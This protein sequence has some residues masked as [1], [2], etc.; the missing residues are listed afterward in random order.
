MTG[1]VN[2]DLKGC[3]KIHKR[4]EKL[5]KINGKRGGNGPPEKKGFYEVGLLDLCTG[6][7][8]GVRKEDLQVEGV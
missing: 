3:Q 1:E 8:R 7:R 6:M 5:V 2:A 4:A